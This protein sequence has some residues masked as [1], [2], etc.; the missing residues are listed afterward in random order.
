MSRGSAYVLVISFLLLTALGFVTLLST[1]PYSLEAQDDAMFGVRRQAVWLVLGLTA[2]GF[3]SVTDYH[4]LQRWAGP[5]FWISLLLL[6]CCFIPP[7]GVR[8]S[9]ASRWIRM[10]LPGLG[11]FTGQPSELA[12]LT[13]VIALAAWCTRFRDRRKDFLRGFVYPLA[14]VALPV[15]LIA[16]EVD[17][18]CASLIFMTCTG[19]LFVAGS[20]TIYVLGLIVMGG[21]LLGTAIT[22]IANRNA[23][24]AA[25]V[26]LHDPD[27]S[28][29][30]DQ[31]RDLNHQQNQ[32]MIALGSGGLTGQG[33]GESRQKLYFLPLPHTDSVFAIIG[34][35]GGLV[36]TW[37][38]IFLFLAGG[39][40]GVIIALHA[41]DRF[42]K[43]L[44]FGLMSLIL[45][46]AIINIAVTTGCLPNKGMP[47]PF[48]S[49]GGSNLFS[50]LMATG[51]V[52]N[53]YLQAREA[54]GASVPLL[55]R[56]KLTPAV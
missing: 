15:G 19:M 21:L 32:A 53:I 8:V 39:L 23:R 40:S 33:L 46:Q 10:P 38:V 9:G 13:T 29:P 50:C 12:K 28:K 4:R 30:T 16:A 41:P 14:M 55:G 34:E 42:G 36:A 2:A 35:E 48:I 7:F 25:F 45:G 1:G 52:L 44:G 49:Y 6:A 37:G 3:L 18:G 11:G 47:L 24:I 27:A 5:I 54:A 43:L 31:I 20:R 17:L 26:Q 56:E 22:M 51:I